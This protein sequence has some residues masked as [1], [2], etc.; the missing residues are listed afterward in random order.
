MALIAMVIAVTAAFAFKPAIAKKSRF[1]TDYYSVADNP[2]G[3]KWHWVTTQPSGKS[4]TDGSA[5]CEIATSVPGT[6]PANGFPSS[7]TVVQGPDG[8]SVYN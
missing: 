4:C 5:T 3:S 6:P 8:A 7:Y 2:D 1:T